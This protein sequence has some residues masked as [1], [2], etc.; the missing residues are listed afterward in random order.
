[1]PI[2]GIAFLIS[3]KDRFLRTDNIALS[4]LFKNLQRGMVAASKKDRSII[5]KKRG[6][7]IVCFLL[8]D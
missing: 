8:T 3:R 4:E 7:H 2:F 1:V 5:N 6:I